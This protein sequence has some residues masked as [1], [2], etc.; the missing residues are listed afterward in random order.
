MVGQIWIGQLL[1]PTHT[2][3][4]RERGALCAQTP[5]RTA[6]MDTHSDFAHCC[7]LRPAQTPAITLI[8]NRKD[9]VHD[10]KRQLSGACVLFFSLAA[11][12]CWTGACRTGSGRLLPR[13]AHLFSINQGWS[14]AHNQ[15]DVLPILGFRVLK[16][17]APSA[18]ATGPFRLNI[19]GCLRMP[20][21]RV[22]VK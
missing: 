1:S 19:V 15:E 22:R 2:H 9:S 20:A 8:Q 3:T 13:A 5:L 14:W 17:G 10:N 18:T 16:T 12:S 4:Q 11:Q 6:L 7:N 21:E